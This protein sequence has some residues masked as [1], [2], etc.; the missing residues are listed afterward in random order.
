M[1]TLHTPVFYQYR[2]ADNWKA[3]KCIYLLGI[4]SPEQVQAIT[5]KLDSHEFF[6]PTQVGLSP[7]QMTLCG[8][9]SDADHVWHTLEFQSP[10]S[11]LPEGE[12]DFATVEEFVDSFSKIDFWDVS[13]EA[14]SL[15]IS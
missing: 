15:G 7:L 10:V 12:D 8:E 6:I 5:A 2:D 9:L 13:K 4:I 1:S 11:S 3:S 14:E